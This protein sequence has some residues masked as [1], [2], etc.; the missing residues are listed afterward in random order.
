MEEFGNPDAPRRVNKGASPGVVRGLRG[1]GGP[2]RREAGESG[3]GRGAH[4]ALLTLFDGG[5]LMKTP[6]TH[7]GDLTCQAVRAAES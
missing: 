7:P 1:L 2:W 6:M 4:P 5:L 3:P